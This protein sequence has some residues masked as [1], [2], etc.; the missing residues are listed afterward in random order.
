MSLN[1]AQAAITK[2]R[3]EIA[4]EQLERGV[5]LLKSKLRELEAAET[6]VANIKREIVDLEQRIEHGNV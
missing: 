3:N 4:Q 5:E 6:V 2:A 1:K